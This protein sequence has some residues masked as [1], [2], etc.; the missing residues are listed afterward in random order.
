MNEAEP[1]PLNWTPAP[2]IGYTV[3]RRPDGG[4]N[5]TFSDL[6]PATLEHWR[7]FALAHLLDS[8]RLTRNLYDLRAI[9]E[10]PPEAMQYAAEVGSAPAAGNTRLAVLVA[11][12]EIRAALQEIAALIPTRTVE[13]NIFTSQEEA[14]DWLRRPLELLS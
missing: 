6:S 8:D 1:K 9:D 12:P 14:E 4:L 2:G 7:S 5:L 10:I 11:S 3:P 13:L